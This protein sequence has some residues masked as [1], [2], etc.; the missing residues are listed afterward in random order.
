MGYL[1]EL[2]QREKTLV[3]LLRLLR[4]QREY[5]MEF[6]V[7]YVDPELYQQF[8]ELVYLNE[9]CLGISEHPEEP[10]NTFQLFYF[11]IAH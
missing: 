2:L 3:M 6:I 5:L 10:L 4:L 1:L 9:L 7:T 8:I 11:L